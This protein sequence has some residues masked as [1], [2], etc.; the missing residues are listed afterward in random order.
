LLALS[1]SEFVVV[2]ALARRICAA[3]AD[4]APSVDAVGVARWV[5]GYIAQMDVDMARDLRRFLSYIEQVAPLA[6]GHSSRFSFLSPSAQDEVLRGLE[7]SRNDLFRGGFQGVKALV[8]MGYYRDPRT[9][10]VLDYDGPTVGRPTRVDEGEGEG[11]APKK[12]P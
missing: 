10:S 1:V 4:D 7:E 11:A 3:D 8:F 6:A 12:A 2:R 5:D 9:W